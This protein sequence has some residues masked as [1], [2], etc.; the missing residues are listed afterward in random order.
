ML[1]KWIL[2][3]MG[4]CILVAGERRRFNRQDAETQREL[5]V[6][7]EDAERLKEESIQAAVS[8]K[9]YTIVFTCRHFVV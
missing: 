6:S 7:R 8:H 5:L 2:E 9:M 4:G 1:Q 3:P